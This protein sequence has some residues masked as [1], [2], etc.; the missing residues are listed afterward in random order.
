[1]A[2]SFIVWCIVR[3]FNECGMYWLQ[4][5]TQFQN[6]PFRW[7]FDQGSKSFITHTHTHTNIE[8]MQLAK[9]ITFQ[10]HIINEFIS[11]TGNG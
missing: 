5:L 1:M 2:S 9:S 3:Y 7:H 6:T 10:Y 8:N 4:Q 11:V